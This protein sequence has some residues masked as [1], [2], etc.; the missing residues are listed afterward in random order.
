VRDTTR[1]TST[2]SVQG[3]LTSA[4]GRL[5]FAEA[6]TSYATLRSPIDG[7]VTDRPLFPGETASAGTAVVTVMDTSWLL[8]KL[9]VAQAIAQRLRLG[10]SAELKLPGVQETQPATLSFISPALDPGS[11]T[12]EIWLKLANADG[13]FKVGTPVHAVVRGYTVPQAIQVPPAAILPSNGGSTTVLIVGGDGT[14]HKRTVTVGL[15]TPESVQILDGVTPGDTVIT[16]GGY[17]LEDG[18]KVKVSSDQDHG[19]TADKKQGSNRVAGHSGLN[20]NKY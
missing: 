20:G 19:D 7:V 13:Q 18:A 2:E 10:A 1:E 16:E 14:A 6:Q 3:Q 11:T 12:V 4:R 15:R 9:H 8:A 5:I 17:G